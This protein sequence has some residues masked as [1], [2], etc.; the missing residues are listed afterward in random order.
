M[1]APKTIPVGSILIPTAWTIH[2]DHLSA[3]HIIHPE[4]RFESLLCLTM[5]PDYVLDFGWAMRDDGLRFSLQINHGH[6]G[7]GNIVC[8]EERPD[9]GSAVAALQ[10]WLDAL[11]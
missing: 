6:F 2:W 3:G 1:T 10:S 5:P 7:E 8:F 9:F 11:A 4:L